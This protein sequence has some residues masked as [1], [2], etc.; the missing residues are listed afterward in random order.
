MLKSGKGETAARKDLRAQL[1]VERLTGRP[2]D[3]GEGYVSPDMQNGIDREGAARAAYEAYRGVLVTDCAFLTKGDELGFSPDGLVGD[4]GLVE[5]KS[6]KLSTHLAYLKAAANTPLGFQLPP[7]YGPQVAH[8]LHVSGRAWCDFVSY[9]PGWPA[10]LDLL[11]I[12]V[13]NG[14]PAVGHYVALLE[15]F[16]VEMRHELALMVAMLDA[17]ALTE[18][19]RMVGLP[20]LDLWTASLEG[21]RT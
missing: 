1:V 11:V 15:A 21:P 12:R 9:C 13:D 18:V 16:L 6:P 14:T 4:E 10:P 19:E 8:G 3:V 20:P 5:T 2:L 7:D 17:L